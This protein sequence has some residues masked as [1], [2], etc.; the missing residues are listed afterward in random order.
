[1]EY[2]WFQFFY[3]TNKSWLVVSCSARDTFVNRSTR[4][5]VRGELVKPWFARIAT[6]ALF[7][8]AFRGTTPAQPSPP[9]ITTFSPT[10]RTAGSPNNFTL[11]LTGANFC[12][13]AS[14]GSVINFNGVDHTAI[15]PTAT[16]S[17]ALISGTELQA[18]GAAPIIL[19]N[20]AR[21]GGLG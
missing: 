20:D 11:T 9:S 17:S 15:T 10:Q 6:A 8:S 13:D 2:P 18:P 19:K 14:G 12:P 16:T 21:C 3:K 1:M 4:A 5:N 7:F